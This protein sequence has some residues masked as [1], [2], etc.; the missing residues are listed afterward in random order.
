[1]PRRGLGLVCAAAVGLMNCCRV[2]TEQSPSNKGYVVMN[3][4]YTHYRL[5]SVIPGIKYANMMSRGR[6]ER[7]SSSGGMRVGNPDI[8]R[9]Y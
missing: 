8:D 7:V 4:E 3:T 2:M 5:D 6:L 9:A 1:M